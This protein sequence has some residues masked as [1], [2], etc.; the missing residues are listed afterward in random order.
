MT[1]TDWNC[2]GKQPVV[3]L[4]RTKIDPVVEAISKDDVSKYN[5]DSMDTLDILRGVVR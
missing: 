2:D 4:D 3:I 1:G 5:Y